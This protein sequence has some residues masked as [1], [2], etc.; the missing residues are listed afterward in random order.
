MTTLQERL[1]Q[2]NGAAY[3][4]KKEKR[5][6]RDLWPSESVHTE[7]RQRMEVSEEECSW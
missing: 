4:K 1:F 2:T 3:E 5:R 6:R 7:G